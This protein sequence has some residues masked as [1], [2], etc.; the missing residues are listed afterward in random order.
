MDVDDKIASVREFICD[1][2]FK[3]CIESMRMTH[4]S[5]KRTDCKTFANTN[6]TISIFLDEFDP[7]SVQSDTVYRP[8]G[9]YLLG[10]DSL[11]LCLE[12]PKK[13]SPLGFILFPL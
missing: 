2:L 9:F 3:S 11:K 13:V 5:W 4:V 12:T 7:T 1:R 8:Q 10:R 6:S